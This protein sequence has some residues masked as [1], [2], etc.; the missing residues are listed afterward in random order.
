MPSKVGN[1]LYNLLLEVKWRSNEQFFSDMGDVFSGSNCEI[2]WKSKTW[3]PKRYEKDACPCWLYYFSFWR[4]HSR[5]FM[6]TPWDV[7]VFSSH[8]VSMFWWCIHRGTFCFRWPYPR[9]WSRQ[10]RSLCDLTA[11]KGRPW[12]WKKRTTTFELDLF[13]EGKASFEEGTTGRYWFL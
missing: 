9:Q 11:R 7:Y 4:I 13:L 2:L 10:R 3:V 6:D 5:H 8:Q 12:Q 1:M